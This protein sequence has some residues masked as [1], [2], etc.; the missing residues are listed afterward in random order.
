[1][2]AG[3]CQNLSL[4]RP[5]HLLTLPG[6]PILYPSSTPWQGGGEE[7]SKTILHDAVMMDTFVK[8]REC[9]PQRG[10]PSVN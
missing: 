10:K 1:M 7:M 2:G 5:L 6:K 8:T 3:L 9:A 4:I